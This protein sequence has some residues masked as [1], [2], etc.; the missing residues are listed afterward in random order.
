[1][2]KPAKAVG[3]K[4][5]AKEHDDKITWIPNCMGS[6]HQWW[7]YRICFGWCH[8][9]LYC[10]DGD[11][12]TCCCLCTDFEVFKTIG[13]IMGWLYLSAG[14]IFSLCMIFMAIINVKTQHVALFNNK[15]TNNLSPEVR[16]H[17]TTMSNPWHEAIQ[18]STEQE[19]IMI[20]ALQCLSNDGILMTFRVEVHFAVIEANIYKNTRHFRDQEGLF[21]YVK[22]ISITAIRDACG[23]FL[24]EHF[25][26]S[27]DRV[28]DMMTTLVK[29]IYKNTGDYVFLE[30]VVLKNVKLPDELS[31]AIKSKKSK[32]QEIAIALE[33][34][35]KVLIIENNK[36]ESAKIS[37]LEIIINAKSIADANIVA[38]TTRK[39]AKLEEWFQIS[40][41]LVEHPSIENDKPLDLINYLLRVI[42]ASNPN[43]L[44]IVDGI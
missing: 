42:V 21:K 1:M 15:W 40:V 12:Y 30:K 3:D 35:E 39:N 41:E 19:A 5:N 20:D 36:L 38:A 8:I 32:E 43:T 37:G 28:N 25:T 26:S 10:G 33:D 27:R 44:Y 14:I 34:R 18:Y 24:S 9:P 7:P 13:R 17:G 16:Q 2:G 4:K 11:V 22:V 29:Q 23:K 31:D 6:K